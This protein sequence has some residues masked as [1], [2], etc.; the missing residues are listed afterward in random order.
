MEPKTLYG[1]YVKER[2]NKNILER[3][4]GFATYSFAKDHVYIE[5]IYVTP[6]HR[7]SSLASEMADEIAKI[8]KSQGINVMLG[9]V[10][11]QTNNATT[12][13]RVLLAYGFSLL[14]S[15]E[16]MIYFKKEI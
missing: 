4:H 14:H 6:E 13:I 3:E 12:S 11:P 2:E 7:K 1:K 15:S 10:C 5:D 9:S 8:A 16:D